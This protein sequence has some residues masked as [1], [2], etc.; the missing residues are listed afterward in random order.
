MLRRKLYD[1]TYL[2]CA[3]TL[4]RLAIRFFKVSARTVG[5]PATPDKLFFLCD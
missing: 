1:A 2:K 5:R 3:D 4:L